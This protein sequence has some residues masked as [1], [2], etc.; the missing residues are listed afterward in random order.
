M[1]SKCN[2]AVVTETGHW[3]FFQYGN[4]GGDLETGWD[5]SACQTGKNN[6][7]QTALQ[8]EGEIETW[9]LKCWR[10]KEEELGLQMY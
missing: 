6:I 1:Y 5:N 10:T 9:C 2:W 4:D 3:G 8:D 7:E